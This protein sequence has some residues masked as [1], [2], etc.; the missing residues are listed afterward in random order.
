MGVA[1]ACFEKT[2]W[3]DKISSNMLNRAKRGQASKVHIRLWN[4]KLETPVAKKHEKT[5]MSPRPC[6]YPQHLE[7]KKTIL[8]LNDIYK[9]LV[10]L[11]NWYMS[12]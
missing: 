7:K 2:T 9:P 1:W 3:C 11:M 8:I 10:K 6:L 4:H 12:D 5:G